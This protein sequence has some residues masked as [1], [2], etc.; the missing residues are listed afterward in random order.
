MKNSST[1]FLRLALMGIGALVIVMSGFAIPS[2]FSEW[3]LEFP[4]T[5]YARYPIA[6]GLVLAVLT[7]FV[8]FYHAFHLL[9]L[10]DDNKSFTLGSVRRLQYVK[11]CAY[12]VVAIFVTGMPA[13]YMVADKE[14]APGLI[15]IVGSVFIG[16][17]AIVA[18]FAGVCQRLFQN[19]IK[20]KSEND[21]TV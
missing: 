9:D 15:V 5:A 7:M 14:D 6:A 10:I 21:L 17:P 20:L 2:I 16:I 4:D 12:A 19:A 8:A 1:M 18:V 3:P 13:V 11:Y